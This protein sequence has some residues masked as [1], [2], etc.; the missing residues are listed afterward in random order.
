VIPKNGCN[1]MNTTV[2]APQQVQ[3][4]KLFYCLWDEHRLVQN[5]VYMYFLS[6][7]AHNTFTMR[8]LR[9]TI[10]CIEYWKLVNY[11]SFAVLPWCSLLWEIHLHVTY[12]MKLSSDSTSWLYHSS[13]IKI[14]CGIC[15]WKWLIMYSILIIRK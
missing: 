10:I 3:Y 15:S 2:K 6:G 5:W 9:V 12:L 8:H 13:S 4:G 7:Q 14:S 1:K 11:C